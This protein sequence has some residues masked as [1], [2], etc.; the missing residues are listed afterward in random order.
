MS[1]DDLKKF[2]L[3]Q[4]EC[5]LRGFELV[6]LPGGGA[7]IVRRWNLHR[8]CDTLQQ[9]EAFLRRV[10]YVPQADPAAR[11][12]HRCRVRGLWEPT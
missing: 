9:V 3:L 10:G 12:G 11:S 4:A 2:A 5:A 7:Y 6:E 8:E 1:E